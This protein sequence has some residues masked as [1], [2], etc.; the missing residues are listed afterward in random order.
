[1]IDLKKDSSRMYLHIFKTALSFPI[2]P[3]IKPPLGIGLKHINLANIIY[4]LQF[5][6][7]NRSSLTLFVTHQTSSTSVYILEQTGISTY[8]KS[9]G[10]IL[11]LRLC[12]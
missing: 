3:K 1:M 2:C 11:S 9:Y 6:D 7:I 10:L 12:L 8:V 4:F 5:A